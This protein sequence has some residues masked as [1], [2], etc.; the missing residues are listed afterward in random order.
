MKLAYLY[1]GLWATTA[2]ADPFYSSENAEQALE[3]EP[4]FAKNDFAENS[5]PITTCSPP[6]SH[7]SLHLGVSFQDLRLIGIVKFDDD[8]RALFLDDKQR[9]I[10][11]K[12][13]D[14]LQPDNIEIRAMDLKSVRYI[15]WQKV[16]DCQNPTLSTLKF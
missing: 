1:L 6:N 14:I 7:N 2:A 4:H 8:Y 9:I 13:D 3:N 11:L 5:L 15:D 16:R 12:P 10:D